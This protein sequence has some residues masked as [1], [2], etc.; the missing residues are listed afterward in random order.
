ML[1]VKKGILQS[2]DVLLMYNKKNKLKKD[3]GLNAFKYKNIKRWPF[4]SFALIVVYF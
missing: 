4:F 3:R 2:P 1:S